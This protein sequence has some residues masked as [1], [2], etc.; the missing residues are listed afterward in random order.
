[1]VAAP[2]GPR[3]LLAEP[4]EAVRALMADILRAAGCS[5]DFESDGD[6]LLGDYDVLVLGPRLGGLS[7]ADVVTRLRDRGAVT[8]VI[9]ICDP[10]TPGEHLEEFA[11]SHHADLLRKPFGLGDLRAS[12]RRVL[13]RG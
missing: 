6:R 9:L 3:A 1:M 7:A 13:S 4:D 12:L 5:V 11:F 10:S 8:P 2:A